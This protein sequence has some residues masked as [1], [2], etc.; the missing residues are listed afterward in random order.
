MTNRRLAIS[1]AATVVFGMLWMPACGGDPAAVDSDS[2]NAHDDAAAD[3]IADMASDSISD[4]APAD[5]GPTRAELTD[6]QGDLMLWVPSVK[7]NCATGEDPVTHIRCLSDT[8]QTPRGIL[9]GW[10]WTVTVGRYPKEQREK[11]YQAAID[12]GYTHFALHVATCT[13]GNFYH[14]LF[15][16]T[17]ADCAKNGEQLNTVLH[18]LIDHRLI[19][20]CAGVSPVDP[21]ADG[22][23]RTLCPLA[24]TDWDNSDQA[25]CR[26]KVVSE[27]F[28]KALVYYELPEGVITPKPTAVRPCHSPRPAQIGSSARRR[29]IPISSVYSPRSTNPMVSTRTPRS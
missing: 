18:E 17:A 13:P 4:S 6:L 27:A 26:I 20:L 5:G 15:P 25:D 28:P 24:M 1:S 3:D 11:I 8:G 10:V 14:G 29:S 23:D 9:A 12:A 2:G 21:P 19:P 7:P 16:T 22:L